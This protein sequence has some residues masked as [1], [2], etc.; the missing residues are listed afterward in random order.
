M[1]YVTSI[2]RLAR[3]EGMAEGKAEG[4][5]DTLLQILEQRWATEIPADLAAAIRAT[6]DLAQ[7]EQWVDLALQVKSLEEFRRLAQL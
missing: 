1:S 2:E 6:R 7:L 3:K 5:A 4:K